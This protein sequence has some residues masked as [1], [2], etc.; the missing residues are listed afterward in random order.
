MLNSLPKKVRIVEV[1]PRDGL[2]NEKTI[3]S[4]EDKVTF[5]KMLSQAGLHEIEAGSFVR[6]E[7]IP[8]MS[9]GMELYSAL[10]ND[11]SLKNTKL[12]SL[13]PNEKGL[14]NA[15]SVGVKEIAVFTATS[16]TFNLKNIN[17]TVD[18]SLKRIDGVMARANKEGLKT[19]AYISTVF[20]CPYEGKTSIAEL[21][22]VAYHLENLGVHE[23][24]LGDTIGVANPLQV[25]ETIE[26]LK[27]DFNLNFFAMHF[28]DTRG[29]AV[30]NI[31]ASLELGITSFDSSAGGL[32]GCPYAKGASGNVATEDLVYLF[33]NM[34][35]E[36][37][38]D[39]EKL[40]QASSFI[41]GKLSKTSASKNLTA[42]LAGK[43]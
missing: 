2:Q 34:G 37:G 28:H 26:F 39:M 31:L 29:M 27:A 22:R 36:T 3:V 33:S 43:A 5:I 42:Y 41:L 9:D 15:L 4:L 17:A 7:K 1:G 23:I 20:G 19:R 16:N 10:V 6:A 18:E 32:G 8:Q 13:V 38:I 30:A 25:K 40:A 35:I 24:S 21:K 14:D 11:G 12:I